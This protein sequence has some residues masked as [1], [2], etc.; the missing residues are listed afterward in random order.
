MRES[1]PCHPVVAQ[2]EFRIS[3]GVIPKRPRFYQRAEE[4]PKAQT[5]PEQPAPLRIITMSS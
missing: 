2:F 1:L 3:Q 4:S 5:H